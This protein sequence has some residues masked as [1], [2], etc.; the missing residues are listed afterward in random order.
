MTTQFGN[1]RDYSGVAKTPASAT[2]VLDP[3]LKTLAA[4]IPGI[5]TAK[6][7]LDVGCNGG[8]VSTQ[9]ALDFHAASV[10]GVDIDPQLVGQAEKLFALR[11]SR[12]RPP[13]AAQAPAHVVDYF[14]MSAVLT[15][16]YRIEPER[17]VSRNAST[18]SA[19][20]PR[21]NFYSADWAVPTAQDV[22][23]DYHVILA[24]SVIKWIHLE[25][26]DQGLIAFFAK[27]SA[28]LRSG[29]HLIIEL[30]GWDS[31][32]KAVRPNHAPH[33]KHTLDK[34]EL[35]PETCFDKLLEDQG[36]H[37]CASSHALPR[38]INVYRKV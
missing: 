25:H 7:C 19:R 38:R 27:C 37:L 17:R 26:A 2:H 13:T 15:H 28:S 10:T 3:R 6:H 9:L 8:S 24:L 12:A 16:G 36:L 22:A 35:R 30:Q 32:Q 1:Y 4:L 33:F 31:Y 11:A 20:W 29:G 18:A 23:E 5:F 34:L 21:V 14:P